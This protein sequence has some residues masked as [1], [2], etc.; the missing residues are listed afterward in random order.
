MEY[1]NQLIKARGF[2]NQSSRPPFGLHEK[3]RSG[4]RCSEI[5][6][7]FVTVPEESKNQEL[8]DSLIYS[9]AIFGLTN[10]TQTTAFAI[11]T[12]NGKTLSVTD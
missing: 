7:I 8:C 12:I 5:L 9:W 1:F 6:C 2:V 4:S 3:G 10:P 11:E